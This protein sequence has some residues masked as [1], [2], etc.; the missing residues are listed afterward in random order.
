M[1]DKIM[2]CRQTSHCIFFRDRMHT[3]KDL[4]EYRFTAGHGGGRGHTCN[5]SPWEAKTGQLQVGDQ[6][7]LYSETLA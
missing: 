4:V 5:H 7:G 3:M 2:T 6:P 1:K